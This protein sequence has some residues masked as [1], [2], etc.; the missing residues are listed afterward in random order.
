VNAADR[1]VI[2]LMKSWRKPS[3]RL[4][5]ALSAATVVMLATSSAT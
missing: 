4:T 1:K 3:G 2:V 5:I